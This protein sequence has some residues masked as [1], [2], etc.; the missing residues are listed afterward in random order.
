MNLKQIALLRQM[1]AQSVDNKNAERTQRLQRHR[2][3]KHNAT[4]RRWQ[5]NE[6]LIDDLAA[7][8]MATFYHS[9]RA[10]LI[11]SG[12]DGPAAHMELRTQFMFTRQKPFPTSE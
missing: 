2:G 8:A 4:A 12:S 6:M 11:Q 3:Q 10:Q 9:V 1:L 5:T 7:F